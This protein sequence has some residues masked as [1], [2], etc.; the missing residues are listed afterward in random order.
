MW[1]S[2]FTIT[3]FFLSIFS[4]RFLLLYGNINFYRF[5]STSEWPRKRFAVISTIRLILFLYIRFIFHSLRKHLHTHAR[6]IIFSR[7]YLIFF[8]HWK[9]LYHKPLHCE[10][11]WA[12][13]EKRARQSTHYEFTMYSIFN[14]RNYVNSYFFPSVCSWT[15]KCF[16]IYCGISTEHTDDDWIDD[17]NDYL[18][19]FFSMNSQLDFS[20]FPLRCH[21]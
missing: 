11:S 14:Y 1:L 19:W 20:F 18:I 10:C 5:V 17:S 7:I 16:Q 8:L 12:L 21:F 4:F 13:N 9:H 15:Y 2:I 6:I 3:I